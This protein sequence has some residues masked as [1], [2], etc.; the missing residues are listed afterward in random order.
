MSVE[1]YVLDETFPL[2]YGYVLLPMDRDGKQFPLLYLFHGSGAEGCE[3]W[4]HS[5]KI[6]ERVNK[7][8]EE[9][10]F[11]PM[12]MVM[13]RI[14]RKTP[15]GFKDCVDKFL[16]FTG[17]IEKVYEGCI[18]KDQEHTA[19][20]GYSMGGAAALYCAYTYKTKFLHTA[21][22][23]PGQFAHYDSEDSWIPWN[24]KMDI[25][26]A[27]GAINYIGYGDAEPN[28]ERVAK[29][30]INELIAQGISINEHGL[31]A[32]TTGGHNMGTFS[33]LLE[34]FIKVDIFGTEKKVVD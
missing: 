6:V 25:G 15:G 19:V 14:K 28:F 12:I 21:A 27:P 30:Y 9:S 13:P 29:R 20:A 2:D 8:A 31:K 11:S 22:F 16:D 4:I 34:R 23:S 10:D 1:R 24:E 18:F 17:Y 32:K 26:K 5:G 7:W 33:V 3:E